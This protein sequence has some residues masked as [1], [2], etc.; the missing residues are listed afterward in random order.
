MYYVTNRI[1]LEAFEY[2]PH[3]LKPDWFLKLQEHGAMFEYARTLKTEPYVE[4]ESNNINYRAYTGYKIY[5]D[6]QGHIGTYPPSVFMIYASKLDEN[7]HAAP[8]FKDKVA[9]AKHGL[10]ESLKNKLKKLL[11]W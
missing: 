8:F 9:E 4:W 6:Q 5:I 11:T 1:S 7:R 10:F 2:D 3:G